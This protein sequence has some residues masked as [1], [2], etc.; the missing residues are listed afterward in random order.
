MGGFWLYD[1]VLPTLH[2]VNKWETMGRWWELH[3]ACSTI[4]KGQHAI[5]LAGYLGL[6]TDALEIQE[7]L[8]EIPWSS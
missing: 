4:V 5:E 7:N 6:A 2:T 1:T 3:M 8:A